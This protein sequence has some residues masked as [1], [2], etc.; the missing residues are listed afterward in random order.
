MFTPQMPMTPPPASPSAVDN[1]QAE[2]QR[3]E[4]SDAALRAA[5]L[6]GRAS[7][8]RG[9]ND[10]AYA[11]QRRRAGSDLLATGASRSMGL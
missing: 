7:T 5:T 4:A 2:R 10:V 1:A 11:A 3:Q 6:G 8:I 9:G